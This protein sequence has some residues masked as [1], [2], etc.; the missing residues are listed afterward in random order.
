MQNLTIIF[1]EV[2]K[3]HLNVHTSFLSKSG[4]ICRSTRLW[5]LTNIVIIKNNN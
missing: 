4:S 2:D 5:S 1:S 3:K